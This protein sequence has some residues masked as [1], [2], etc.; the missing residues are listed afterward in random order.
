[1]WDYQN[2]FILNTLHFMNFTCMYIYCVCTRRIRFNYVFKPRLISYPFQH[3]SLRKLIC[4]IHTALFSN[5]IFWLSHLPSL[6]CCY[7]I[8]FCFNI[9]RWFRSFPSSWKF[10]LAKHIYGSIRIL[11]YRQ[12]TRSKVKA[13]Q[14]RTKYLA[15]S[16]RAIVKV[17][18]YTYKSS[19]FH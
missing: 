7:I 12:L 9:S 4:T 11:T 3:L 8:T 2:V 1:M 5:L 18:A 16:S 15:I 6:F 14:K 13:C 17:D 10:S 19:G